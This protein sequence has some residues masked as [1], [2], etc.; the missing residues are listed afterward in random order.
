MFSELVVVCV[1]LRTGVLGQQLTGA[2]RLTKP[3]HK[4]FGIVVELDFLT[5]SVRKKGAVQGGP[6]LG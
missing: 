1:I 3:T 6:P 2:N 4:G 5:G